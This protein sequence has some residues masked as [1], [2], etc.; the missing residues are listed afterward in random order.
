MAQHNLAASYT[1]RI[2]GERADNQ[3][4]TI[5]LLETTLTV[6]TLEAFPTNWANTQNTLAV[7]YMNRIRGERADNLERA[8]GLCEA[9]LTVR[10]REAF[11]TG[12]AMTQHNLATAYRDRI[13]GERA[14]NLERAIG[15]FEAALTVYTR[16]AFPTYWAVSQR[17]LADAYTE[18]IRGER[19]DNLVRA[20]GFYEAAV[21]VYTRE[22]SPHHHL[23]VANRLGRVLLE[24]RDWA[25]TSH[26]L[27][28]AR[29]TFTLLFGQGL[30]EAEAHGLIE[31]A[32]NLFTN[33]AFA[34]AAL[35]AQREAFA[36]A[37]EGKARLLATALRLQRLDL[38]PP[39]RQRLEVLR[40]GIREQ[41]SLL[42][43]S[44]GPDRVLVLDRLASMRRELF[45]LIEE[46]EARLGETDALV[47]A[48]LLLASGGAIV[49]PLVTPVGGKL[50]LATAGSVLTVLDVPQLMSRQLNDLMQG[51]DDQTGWLAAFRNVPNRRRQARRLVETIG[52]EL[53]GLFVGPLAAALQELGVLKGSRLMV[54]PSG[55]L[56][57]LPLG[58]A[59]D[60][61]SGRRLIEEYE[62]VC[63]PSL[64]AL[65]RAHELAAR[66]VAPSLAAIVNPTRD[67]AFAP[68]EGML[69]AAEFGSASTV[70]LDQETATPEA[71][72]AAL[73]GR[74][75]WHFA[76]HGRFDFDAARH[77]ALA[78]KEGTRLTV[79]TLLETE[80]L[81]RPRLVVLSACESGLH[82]MARMPEEFVGLPCAFITAGGDGGARHAL[83]DG[84]SCFDAVDGAVLRI[85][86][87]TV[88][89]ACGVA[90]AGAAMVARRDPCGSCRL[91]PC[92]GC[93]R[94]AR[95]QQNTPAGTSIGPCPCGG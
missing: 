66:P 42:D 91:Y 81:G 94:P 35:G 92:G 90:A 17:S 46:G 45:G 30:D 3:E 14:D 58:L 20:I 24:T 47:M 36:I 77:S 44:S 40:T 2:R 54:L 76:T 34:A 68:I 5:G 74:S 82:D 4:R 78:M 51:A 6:F 22:A 83:A 13:R 86:S 12:W 15:L 32:G 75:Y 19:A 38:P 28:E 1:N 62:I 55:A 64:S 7:T 57:F 25:R 41:S 87:A 85:A 26:V 9:A 18:R 49:V 21:T 71:A 88:A 95:R 80:D 61:A 60:P 67:L 43:V 89:V 8:I 79:G 29:S 73:K 23:A 50:L 69:V 59:Q 65:V 39:R 31:E 53:W 93:R 84:R 52:E 63:G 72:L 70:M 16:E 10:T 56:G 33:A 27:A 11:P 37:C 48:Q